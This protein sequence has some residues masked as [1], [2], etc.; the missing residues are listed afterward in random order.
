MEI[1]RYKGVTGLP[2]N[3][4]VQQKVKFLFFKKSSF[5]AVTTSLLT[6]SCLADTELNVLGVNMDRNSQLLRLREITN[7]RAKI[8]EAH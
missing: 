8:K 6:Y 5:C 4:H 1:F 3:V 2:D 7:I